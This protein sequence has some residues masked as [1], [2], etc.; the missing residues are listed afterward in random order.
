[1]LYAMQLMT[2]MLLPSILAL[3]AICSRS[4]FRGDP[5]QVVC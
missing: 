2:R 3:L 5:G 1:M 4:D